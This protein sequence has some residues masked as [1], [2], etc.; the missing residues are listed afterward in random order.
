MTSETPINSYTAPESL[1][2]CPNGKR[3][4]YVMCSS[5]K[6]LRIE[7]VDVNIPFPSRVPNRTFSYSDHEAVVA[8]FCVL[9]TQSSDKEKDRKESCVASL[10]EASQVCDT[11]LKNLSNDKRNYTLVFGVVFFLLAALPFSYEGSYLVHYTLMVSQLLLT[12]LAVFCFVMATIWNRIERHGI[13]AG[14]LGMITR[15]KVL[16]DSSSH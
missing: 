2:V 10:K 3:I 6:G 5:R 15:L 11:A 16:D 13:L 4:D 14:Q 1:R 8:K 12:F 7:T 9:E